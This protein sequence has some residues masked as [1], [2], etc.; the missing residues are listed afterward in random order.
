M[1][2]EERE[3]PPMNIFQRTGLSR[4]GLTG[5][6]GTIL[7]VL[8]SGCGDGDAVTSSGIAVGTPNASPAP[9]VLDESGGTDDSEDA[10]DQDDNGVE[11]PEPPEPPQPPDPIVRWGDVQ[12]FFTTCGNAGCHRQAGNHD[13]PLRNR[14]EITGSFTKVLMT[15]ENGSMPQGG[16]AL[17]PDQIQLLKRWRADGFR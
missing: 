1:L 14:A 6:I 10:D 11:P 9:V 16:T 17:T 3:I 7:L 8:L 15:L 5:W 4:V 2:R 13:T 12:G